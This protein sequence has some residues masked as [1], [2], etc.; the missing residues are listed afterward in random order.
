MLEFLFIDLL[1]TNSVM[2]YMFSASP[3]ALKGS[4]PQNRPG[5]SQPQAKQLSKQAYLSME[6]LEQNAVLKLGFK[7]CGT[8]V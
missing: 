5:L 2:L 3:M 4:Y 6:L 1:S 7:Y 8:N